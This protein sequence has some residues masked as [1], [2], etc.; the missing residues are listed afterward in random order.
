MRMLA[1]M[2]CEGL[3]ER[4]VQHGVQQFSS[5][6]HFEAFGRTQEKPPFWHRLASFTHLHMHY[7]VH[8]HARLPKS[9]KV[10]LSDTSSKCKP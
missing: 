5:L 8:V 9:E 1:S 3:R 4:C 10:R 7:V 2:L 6:L